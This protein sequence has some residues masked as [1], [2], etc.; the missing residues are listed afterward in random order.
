MNDFDEDSKIKSFVLRMWAEMRDGDSVSHFSLTEIP[1]GRRH[2][3]TTF[4]AMEKFLS[5][6]SPR[7]KINKEVKNEDL[8][9]DL[10]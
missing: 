7:W 6:V 10:D 8:D 1:S 5:R 3:F 4:A 9:D 2:G